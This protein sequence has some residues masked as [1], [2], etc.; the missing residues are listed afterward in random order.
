[1]CTSVFDENGFNPKFD[2][3]DAIYL[4][5]DVLLVTI[6]Q[7]P[8][9]EFFRQED[10]LNER[11]RLDVDQLTLMSNRKEGIF[12][13]G[14]VKRI[15][16]AVEAMRDGM[17][18]AES[19]DRYLKGE[20]LR[21]GREKDYESAPIPKRMDYKPQPKLEWVL[22]KEHLSFELFERGFT[23]EE[24]VEEAKRCLYCG[25]CKSCK[26][27]VALELQL[28]IPEIEVNEDLCS[29]C[30]VCVAVCAY[31]APKVVKS[32]NKRV[33]V[34]DTLRCK[35]CGLCVSAC[36]SGAVTIKDGLAETIADAYATL[37]L[38]R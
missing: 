16:F 27:C 14:D 13:G 7:G 32:D 22:M 35:R 3:G 17:I 19:I 1:R 34:I 15:G 25:P 33:A 5:G 28:E 8:E 24:A 20:D 38:R 30:G 12:I 29:G 18:A 2:L 37:W 10:L 4:E 11:S 21:P 26:A 23:L 36:P 31:D 6:G 9:R